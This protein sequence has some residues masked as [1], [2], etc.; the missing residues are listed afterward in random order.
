MIPNVVWGSLDSTILLE[1]GENRPDKLTSTVS[2]RLTRWN[3]TVREG[4][5]R[6]GHEIINETIRTIMN[7]RWKHSC[8]HARGHGRLMHRVTKVSLAPCVETIFGTMTKKSAFLAMSYSL[9]S[10]SFFTLLMIMLITVYKGTTKG[11]SK[12]PRALSVDR[13]Y[14]FQLSHAWSQQS[15][16]M[17]TKMSM[18]ILAK[19]ISTQIHN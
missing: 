13:H 2:D 14:S 16:S 8:R 7:R 11:V 9:S 18:S 10:S 12:Q 15:V 19:G 6:I 5:T 3:L 4:P 1:N 17:A